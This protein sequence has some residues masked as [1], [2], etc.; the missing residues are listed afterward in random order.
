MILYQN[1][2]FCKFFLRLTNKV[3]P[4]TYVIPV[5]TGIQILP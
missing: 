1:I 5:K 3:T 2:N 4:H